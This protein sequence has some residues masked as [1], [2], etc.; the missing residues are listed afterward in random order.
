MH[1][2]VSGTKRTFKCCESTSRNL[3][4][5]T[6]QPFAV[7]YIRK[8]ESLILPEV[9]FGVVGHV[10]SGQQSFPVFG[11]RR[12]VGKK[13][14]SISP[15]FHHVGLLCPCGPHKI[16]PVRTH[17]ITQYLTLHGYF[18]SPQPVPGVWKPKGCGPSNV[19]NLNPFIFPHSNIRFILILFGTLTFR[20]YWI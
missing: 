4:W 12:G 19:T 8:R 3:F 1:L 13:P 14:V 5:C 11:E 9:L 6:T 17:I 7:C 16:E 18:F 15:A 20:F 10:E 2:Y